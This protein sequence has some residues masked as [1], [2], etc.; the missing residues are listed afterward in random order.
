[1]E[2]LVDHAN[3][4][5]LKETMQVPKLQNIFQHILHKFVFK[6][7]LSLLFPFI[8]IV[9]VTCNADRTHTQFSCQCRAGYTGPKCDRCDYGYYGLNIQSHMVSQVNECK[10]CK[11]N[12]F[13]SLTD[14]CDQ[15]TGQCF[16]VQGGVTGRDCS[17]CQV[18]RQRIPI[19]VLYIYIYFAL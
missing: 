12:S 6:Y 14:Q 4:Q 17:Q 13:G 3:A 8:S 2:R 15:I 9:L 18:A 7:S 19:N 11:C 10:P 1:M 5:V 16:C